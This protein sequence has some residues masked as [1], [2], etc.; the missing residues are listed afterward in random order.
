MNTWIWMYS[1][2]N[3]K[4]KNKTEKNIYQK[5]TIIYKQTKKKFITGKNYYNI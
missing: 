5:K 2:L 3:S 1:E 4:K